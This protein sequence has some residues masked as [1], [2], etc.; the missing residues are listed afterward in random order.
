VLKKMKISVIIPLFNKQDTIRKTLESVLNQTSLPEEVIVVN[1]GSTDGSGSVVESLKIPF[2][3]LINQVNAG[4]SS[5]RNKGINEAK[6]DWI[7]F[8][9]ADD[10]WMPHFLEKI[11]LLNYTFPECKLIATS[12]LI[13]NLNGIRKQII[14]NRMPFNVEYGKL[15]NYF[16]VS[17]VSHPPVWSSAVVVE[18]TAISRIGG[19]PQGIQSGEDLITWA[20]L[21]T[22]FEIAYSKEPL[23]VFVQ[24]DAKSSGYPTRIPQEPD[25]VGEKLISLAEK[26][27][28]IKGIRK[29]ISHWF[30]MRASVYMRMGMRRKAFSEIIKSLSYNPLNIRVLMYL[31][32]LPFPVSI[33]NKIFLKLGHS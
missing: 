11:K 7:A 28:E 32:V 9:D 10:I 6:G 21:A 5:A 3:R 16:D 27:P 13:Q 8:L 23:S 33:I 12:Y 2:V 4:V 17:S 15:T 30:K 26:H 22:Q 14:L 24:N 29:Y 25:I 19:F 20:R 31:F 1:D 18:K